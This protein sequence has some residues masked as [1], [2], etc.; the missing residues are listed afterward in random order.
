MGIA[1]LS[2]LATGEEVTST[3]PNDS[4][5][6]REEWFYGQR[7]YGLGYI[8]QDA[9]ARAVAQRDGGSITSGSSGYKLQ[10]NSSS[11]QSY[12][13]MAAT[14]QDR[15]F[16]LGP[17]GIN[18]VSNGLIS[19]RITSFALDRRNPSTVYVAAAGGGVWKSTNRGARWS[20]ISDHLAS[21]ASG[22]VAVDP[23]TG[24]IWYGTGELNFCRDCYYGAGVYRSADGGS[25]WARVNQESFLASPTSVIVFDPKAQDTL[26]IG[27]STG[28]WRSGD[29]GQTWKTV[30]QGVITDF[31]FHS[32]DSSIAYAAIGNYSG[33][34]ENGIYRTSDGGQTWTRLTGELPAQPT[35]GRISLAVTPASPATVYALIAR[36]SDFK[37]NGLYRSLDGGNSWTLLS[38]VPADLFTEEG[39][40]HGL[41]NLLV[42]VDPR[43]EGVLYVGGVALWKSTDHGATWA[44]L[45]IAG[46]PEDPD[47]RKIVFDP[48]D[49]Q[50]FYLIGDSG[51]WRSSDKGQSFIN[52]NHTLAVTQFQSVGLHPTNPNLA[53]GGTQ[54][55]GTALYGGGLIW[56]QSRPGDSG[57]A[58]YDSAN[59]NII[60]AVARRTSLRRSDDGGK[61]F[62]LITQGLD[63]NDRVQFYPPFIADPNQPGT[64]YF[65]TQRV[66]Q[67]LDRGD[68]WTALSNDLTGGSSATITALAVAPSNSLTLYAGT[69]DGRVQVSADGGKNWV[70]AAPLPNRFVTSIAVHPQLPEQAIVGLSGFGSGH[71]FLTNDRGSHWQDISSNLPDIPVN[72]V[73]VDA[74]VPDRVYLGTDIGVFRSE[75]D[76]LWSVLNQGIPNAI[77][78][79]LS[80][81]SATGL[82]VAAT[83]GRG[84]FGLAQG[85]LAASAPRITALFNAAGFQNTLVAPGMVAALFGFNLAEV[86]S[87]PFDSPLPISLADTSI[88][89]NGVPAPLLFVSP[90]QINFQVPYESSGGTTEVT[91]RTARGTAT[92]RVQRVPASPGIF[93]SGGVASIYHGSGTQVSDVF[94]ARGGEELMLFASG[95]GAVEPAVESGF[96]APFSPMARTTIPL[97]I[98]V[99]GLS[100]EI[101]SSG[102]MPGSVGLYQVKFVVPTGVSGKVPVV[103]EMNGIQSNSVSLSVA[104]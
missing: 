52:L 42:A 55:N 102:L 25:N 78:L 57:A 43:D 97:G 60:Y 91:V 44:K 17:A 48:S 64:L 50:T 93:L 37:L 89:V 27:R 38:N 71:V 53:V 10:S 5:R 82:L 30:L 18:S 76:G 1:P 11:F 67:S 86:S 101:R 49:P 81:N 90:T 16:I 8:P 7:L 33:S 9:L 4:T 35:M 20:P 12:F 2:I 79:G 70:L 84:V 72:A 63:T 41:F 100:V 6:E 83:H 31:V 92:L 95:L 73:L 13:R 46:A 32:L 58:F 68:H 3:P 96:P 39:E 29:G 36:S 69:S 94:P 99:E 34:P 88:T 54:D 40:G 87:V 62:D 45:N 61:T 65:G 56:E 23:F 75:S 47:P 103:L 24:E 80:Q 104:P 22:A 14:S 74:R 66:W 85:E 98:R 15:W 59:P 51:V 21:L 26:F 19:G 77:V 28:L